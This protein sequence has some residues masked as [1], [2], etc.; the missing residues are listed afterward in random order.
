MPRNLSACDDTQVMLDALSRCDEVIDV[1]AAG[2][3]MRFLTAY[4][5]VNSGSHIVT[6]TERMRRRP[7]G[8]L[9]DSLRS[10][11]A[12][13]AYMEN[14]GYPPLRI[15]G[16]ELRGG[17]LSLPGNVS[18]QYVSALLMIGPALRDGLRLRLM[19]DIVSRPYIDMTISIMNKYGAQASWIGADTIEVG[20]KPY[21]TTDYTV[22]NDWSAASYWYETMAL[23]SDK[24]AEIRLPHLSG[25]SLQGDSRVADFFSAL[26]VVTLYEADGITLMKNPISAEHVEW[27]L[28]NQPDLAQTLVATCCALGVTFRFSGLGNLKIKETDRIM[29]MQ[30]ELRK[31]GFVVSEVGKGSLV[32]DGQK[33]EIGDISAIDTYDDHRMAMAFAPLCIRCGRLR[34]NHPSVVTKSYPDYWDDLRKASFHIDEA[35]ENNCAD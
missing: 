30:T 23:T 11:G 31:L 35:T 34:I 6:G 15:R 5:C 19:G 1:K 7:I 22:E 9:V 10:L 13:I 18:S 8:V 16:T 14:D 26:G 3:A 20:N 17:T 21:T 33:V 4:L 25:D 12:Q 2:T 24:D 29:A 32:W 27:D 28:M